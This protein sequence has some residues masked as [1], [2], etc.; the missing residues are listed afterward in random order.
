MGERRIIRGD[1]RPSDSSFLLASGG[2]MSMLLNVSDNQFELAGGA[3]MIKI[4]PVSQ[5]RTGLQR[6]SDEFAREQAPAWRPSDL[7]THTWALDAT[8]PEAEPQAEHDD[9]R[10]LCPPEV[11]IG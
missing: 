6:P 3:V 2:K 8:H 10:V 1:N 9:A 7:V 4:A 5:N 11:Y